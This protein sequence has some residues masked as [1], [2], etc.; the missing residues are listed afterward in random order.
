MA[1]LNCANCSSHSQQPPWGGAHQ[2]MH[3][4]H[5]PWSNQLSSQQQLNR[6]NLSLN[7][8][9]GYMI[10]PQHNGM[11]P[12]PV[13]MNQRGMVGQMF[14]QAYMGGMPVMNPG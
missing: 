5:D 2:H 9:A 8:A 4:Q 14:P 13:F 7:V 11:Y 12:P 6:S 1:Q 3:M 10:P